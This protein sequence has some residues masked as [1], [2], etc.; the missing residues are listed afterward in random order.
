MKEICKPSGSGH[1]GKAVDKQLL[2]CLEEIVGTKV[3]QLLETQGSFLE[4]L[5]EFESINNLLS[6]GISKKG[7][8]TCKFPL[9]L[10]NKLCKED[11]GKEFQE[12]LNTSKK[13]HKKLVLVN[14][15]L[16]I[17][18]ELIITFISKVA[19]DIVQDIKFVLIKAKTDAI[20]TF[21]VVG[22]FSNSD[23]IRDTLKQAFPTVQIIYPPVDVDLAV[24]KGA[25]LYGQNPQYIKPCSKTK[26]LK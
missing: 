26:S 2:S 5:D 23:V 17:D 4:L 24:V 21:I 11:C 22:G 18:Q 20:K 1:G 25:V 15:R 19:S 9:Y 16:R 7:L 13:Y 3:I 14:D 6:G 10:L 12:L 8:L